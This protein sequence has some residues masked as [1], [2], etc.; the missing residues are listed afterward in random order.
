MRGVDQWIMLICELFYFDV[1][2][3]VKLCVVSFISVEFALYFR[4]LPLKLSFQL[5]L[6][7]AVIHDVSEKSHPRSTF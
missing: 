5:T 7:A 2:F 3:S 1:L 6:L 4:K